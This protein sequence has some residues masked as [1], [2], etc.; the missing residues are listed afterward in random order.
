VEN[1]D[2]FIVGDFARIQT[3]KNKLV[4]VGCNGKEHGEEGK[5]RVFVESHRNDAVSVFVFLILFF[6]LT[7][8][9]W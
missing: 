2:H 7:I 4:A 8:A 3:L 1:N 6:N 9:F 5:E